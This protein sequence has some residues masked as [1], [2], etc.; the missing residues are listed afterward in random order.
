[1]NHIEPSVLVLA[2]RFDLT[3]DYVV[4]ALRR[5]STARYLRLNSEDLSLHQIS[6]EPLGRR[7]QV[8][9]E[10][11]RY[12]VTPESLKSV[13]FRRPVFLR[14]YGDDQRDIATRFSTIQWATFVQNLMI[15][16]E[17][18]WYN[19]PV[20]TYRAEHKAIQLNEASQLGFLVPRTVITNSPFVCP[21]FDGEDLVALKGIDT[22]MA[23]SEGQE[24][25]GFTT[26][27]KA[28]EVV[29]MDWS[30]APGM[31]QEA[32]EQ[33]VDLRVTV[34][35]D[36][37]FAAAILHDRNGIPGDWRAQKGIATFESLTLPPEVSHRCVRLVRQLGLR[38]GAIDLALVN[39][40]YY[41]FEINPTGEWSWLID[42]A[43]LPID[44]ELAYALDF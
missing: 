5:R 10:G 8:E 13:L 30:S 23:R 9:V 14:D 24:F 12:C 20:A 11:Q 39:G 26:F 41:F 19:N 1:M 16:H 6:L 38:F 4:A 31:I 29:Q 3:C 28:D 37:V 17:A 35:D 42:A 32:I 27:A 44:E 33:K 21:T 2:S 25:F 15:F 18:R 7:L 43:G 34:V 36:R 40:A 22:V